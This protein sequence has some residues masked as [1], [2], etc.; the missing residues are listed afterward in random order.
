MTTF[1]DIKTEVFNIMDAN[2]DSGTYRNIVWPKINDVWDKICKGSITSILDEKV[3]TAGDLWFL[4]D[5]DFF[6]IVPTVVLTE[7]L[8][9]T[10]TVAKCDT[11]NLSDEWYVIIWWEKIQY[12][13][14]TST[15]IQG[16]TDIKTSHKA[17]DNVQQLYILP[18]NISL[19]FTA[20]HINNNLQTELPNIDE[21]F[22]QSA[23]RG[24]S[25]VN[26]N[27][28]NLL[29]L[30]GLTQG[31]ILMTYYKKRTT[32]VNDDDV[33]VLPDR[34]PYTVLAMIVA[35][36][37]LYQTEEPDNGVLKL[38]IG[39]NNLN[40][41]YKYY[42]NRIK[43]SKDSIKSKQYNYNSIYPISWYGKRRIYTNN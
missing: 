37:L 22:T 8:E 4:Y 25:I 3:Y 39:Y 5:E 34:Y 10:D 32:L 7:D 28:I 41:M 24:Y 33:C 1:W 17:G 19:P 16:L 15:E 13:A 30:Y 20:F 12:T 38:K 35:W 26:H 36:E 27:G 43:K 31:K 18:T 23:N 6:D 9:V 42:A 11:T 2:S 21:R 40:D 29:R 14:K